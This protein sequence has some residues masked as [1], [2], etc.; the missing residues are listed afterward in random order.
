MNEK[1]SNA[2][3]QQ[4]RQ[5]LR[6]GDHGHRTRALAHAAYVDEHEQ[7]VNREHDDNPH[8]RTAEKRDDQR[9]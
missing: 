2:N 1:N 4:E 9:D 7:A 5:K 3:E 8:Q 6:N